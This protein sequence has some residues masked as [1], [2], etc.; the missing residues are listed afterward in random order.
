MKG[1][2]LLIIS[3]PKEHD[4]RVGGL[5]K[6]HFPGGCYVYVGSALGG[7]KS[8][9]NRH[10]RLD[11]TPKWHVDYLLQRGEVPK[12]QIGNELQKAHLES[13]IICETSDRFECAIARDLRRRFD[14]VP[15][16]GSS[17][18]GCPSHLFFDAENMEL[19]L[20]EIL[21]ALG[22]KPRLLKDLSQIN[23]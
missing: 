19:K 2:Y 1:I 15:G 3:L 21:S 16:F 14:S 8:R 11:K 13:I 4:V 7:F 6:V 10:L 20:T 22:L 12:S 9:L 17:D 23:L 5:G 18:C